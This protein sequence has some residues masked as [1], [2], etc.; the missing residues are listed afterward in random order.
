MGKFKLVLSKI[1]LKL[2][3]WVKPV[4]DIGIAFVEKIIPFGKWVVDIL[5][6]IETLKTAFMI[7]SPIIA[8]LG[9]NY[10]IANASAIAYS[11]TLGILNG[12]MGIVT[13][14]TALFNFVMSMNPIS[15][16]VLAIGALI[17]ASVL[18][19][20]KFDWFRGAVMG[21]WEVLKGLGT[22]IKNYVINRFKEL[23]SG[24]TGIGQ[25]LVSFFKGDWQK[26]GEIG[27]KAGKNLLGV[28]SKKQALQDGMNAFKSFG[29]G[30]EKGAKM[31]APKIETVNNRHF[32]ENGNKT[33]KPTSAIFKGLLNNT[34][35]GLNV[36]KNGLGSKE[37]NLGNKVK[38]RSNNISNGGKRPTNIN[39]TIQKLQDD[40]KIYVSNT[41]QGLS[42]LGDKVQEIL[43]RAINSVNQLQTG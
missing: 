41:E 38:G 18:A 26:A 6:S 14:A 33:T 29:K 34:G 21:V 3:E 9:V 25:A 13:G 36:K 7:L 42:N 12:I 40:T 28:N 17:V 22:M 4:I 11:V 35:V 10:V 32:A 27:E 39:V 19:W 8:A 37:K 20:K 16:V 5:P 43:V 31:Y 30:Y 24:I 23:L 2:A 1:G 15:L